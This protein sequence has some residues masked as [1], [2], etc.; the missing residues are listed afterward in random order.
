MKKNLTKLMAL[1]LVVVMGATA[2]VGCGSKDSGSKTKDGK[3]KLT[4]ALWDETQ[5]KVM[6]KMIDKY[7]EENPNVTVET[8]LS[9]WS[10]YWT[11]LEASATGNDACDIMWMNILHVEEYVEAGIL[12]DLSKV[13]ENL[14]METNF[15]AALADGYTID[16]KL[17][18]IPKDFD[19]NGLFYNKELFDKAGLAY[20]TDDWT[21]EDFWAACEALDAADLGE[22][23]YPTAVNYNS[24]QT[25][26]NATI[27][28]NGGYVYNDDYTATGYSDPKTVEGITIGPIL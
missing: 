26:Y 8:Q 25:N 21:M 17:Y 23:V 24:G 3:T 5:Q 19:T 27:I 20:P 2:A 15:P 11:K 12:K 6:Q 1:G 22:G 16:G 9:T 7:E 13:G 10:E 18:A 4:M 28:A 14:D